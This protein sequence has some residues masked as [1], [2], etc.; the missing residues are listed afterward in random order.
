LVP[1]TG[2]AAA[3]ITAAVVVAALAF[4]W[5]R[6]RLGGVSGDVLGATNEL[7]RVVGLHAGVIAWTLS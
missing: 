6:S 4:A 3:A 1:T 7:A 2:V 5:A